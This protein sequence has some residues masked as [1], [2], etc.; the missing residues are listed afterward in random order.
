MAKDEME[1]ESLKKNKI[2]CKCAY[3]SLTLANL[4]DEQ[5]DGRITKY[6]LAY[7]NVPLAFDD[8]ELAKKFFMQNF[9]VKEEDII[10]IQNLNKK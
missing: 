8:C 6:E 4:D 3:V 10:E 9:F 5:M 1:L 2:L 7:P